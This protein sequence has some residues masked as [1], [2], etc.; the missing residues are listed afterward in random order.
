MMDLA[1]DHNRMSP[2]Y[3]HEYL[4]T[5]Q[6]SENKEHSLLTFSCYENRNRKQQAIENTRKM[7]ETCSNLTIK[8]PE[9]RQCFYYKLQTNFTPF[10]SVSIIL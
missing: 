8:T 6:N 2:L 9:Q 4:R 5:K 7:C 1:S 10:S 3:E